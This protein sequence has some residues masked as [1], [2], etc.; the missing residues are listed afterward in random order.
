MFLDCRNLECPRPVIMTKDALM[1]L[2]NGEELE[3]LVNSIAPKENISR[4]LKSQNLTANITDLPNGETKII[5]KKTGDISNL[6]IN[7]SDYTCEVVIQKPKKVVY[8]NE[9]T[10]GSG[11]V[12]GVLTAKFLGAFL[13]TSQK[14]Y[15]VICVNN[16]VKLTTDRGN[17]SFKVLRDLESAGVKIFSCGTCLEAYGLVDKLGVG[18]ISNA[19]EIAELLMQYEEITL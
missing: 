3:I 4:F 18:E 5:T 17:P 6:Q 1:G 10:A 19:L 2:K 12:G 11:A 8:L 15:A 9:E 16:A 14:P 7:E 13:H